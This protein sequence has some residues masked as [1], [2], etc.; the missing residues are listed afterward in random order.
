MNFG[1]LRITILAAIM[2]SGYTL[3]QDQLDMKIGQ[4][5]MVGFYPNTN[6]EDTLL[7]DIANRNLGGV[8]LFGSNLESPQK[9]VELTTCLKA[10]ATIPLLIATDQEGGVVARLDESNGFAA[11]YSAYKLG[12]TFNSEDSTRKQA[13]E[14]AGW[15]SAS[16][17]NTDL[18]P[19][20]DVNV[21]PASPAIGYYKRSFSADPMI[22]YQHAAWFIDEFRSANL[23]TAL[24]HF[25]GHGSAKKD[26]HLGFTDITDTWSDSELIPYTELIANGYR[27]MV[28]TG[29]LYNANLD[30][31]YPASLSHKITTELLRD[32]LGFEGVVI[33]D[34]LFMRA[35]S[36]NYGFEEA[37]ELA[38]NAGTD[39]L[40]YS[41][42]EH[43]GKSI[44]A[45]ITRIIRQKIDE[46]TISADRI[47]E[48]Y[49]RIIDLK[50]RL[51]GSAIREIAATPAHFSLTV[52]PNPYNISTSF[53]IQLAQAASVK[54]EVYDI[55]GRAVFTQ[56][57]PL[58]NAGRHLI[59]FN[60]NE[61]SSGVYF[62]RVEAGG[63]FISKKIALMK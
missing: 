11:T 60:G 51:T 28:M 29:H 19:V 18:A 30:S 50:E 53:D 8:I 39:I 15:L 23:V 54:L 14:M 55:V 6:Y 36:N 49:R 26:S 58:M 61:L 63:K 1:K 4:M 45:E 9:I 43:G 41:T 44:V 13:A 16:G 22:V 31:I 27:D 56:Q 62:V 10:A 57:Y 59:P 40:L 25:P 7:Y 20:V 12:T 2:M 3:A 52:Y 47:D 38:V 46:G 21:N 35:I 37:I 32:S 34:E 17:I 48:S 5:L 42:N 33:S 24:K